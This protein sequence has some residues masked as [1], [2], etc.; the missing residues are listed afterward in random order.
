MTH[1][2]IAPSR[3]RIL[4]DVAYPKPQSPTPFASPEPRHMNELTHR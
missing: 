1:L 3:H 4:K 2:K